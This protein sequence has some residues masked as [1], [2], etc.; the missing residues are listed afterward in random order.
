MVLNSAAKNLYTKFLDFREKELERK[1]HYLHEIGQG[2]EVEERIIETVKDGSAFDDEVAHSLRDL[3]KDEHDL[4]ERLEMKDVSTLDSFF[5]SLEELHEKNMDEIKDVSGRLDDKYRKP[6]GHHSSAAFSEYKRSVR[7]ELYRDILHLHE[8][9]VYESQMV[10]AYFRITKALLKE[11][12]ELESELTLTE[13]IER[14]R[15]KEGECESSLEKITEEE[16]EVMTIIEDLKANLDRIK[17]IIKE[18]QDTLGDNYRQSSDARTDLGGVGMLTR[19]MKDENV[20][21]LRDRSLG[22]PTKFN[23][24]ESK[25]EG[26]THKTGM[27]GNMIDQLE[28]KLENA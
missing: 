1:E 23:K 20:E 4:V 16:K 21:K 9:L 3:E 26:Y 13:R 19:A 17:E 7:K 25:M 27:H 5:S 28:S 8:G 6:T 24:L 15:E 12:R 22:G 18:F 11:L 10:E 14:K 2:K